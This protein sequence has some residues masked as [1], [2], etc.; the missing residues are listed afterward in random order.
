M[1]MAIR[2]NSGRFHDEHRSLVAQGVQR[3]RTLSTSTGAFP[4][5]QEKEQ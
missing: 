4:V 3:L 2:T 1:V 5:S